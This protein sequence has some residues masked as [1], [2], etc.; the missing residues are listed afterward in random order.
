MLDFPENLPP[1]GTMV[2]HKDGGIYQV[3]AYARHSDDGAPLCIYTHRWPF[4]PGE[5]WARP[6]Q[7]WKERFT[8][9]DDLVYDAASA[10][11]R[12]AA[13]QQVT[14]AKAARKAFESSLKP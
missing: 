6:A 10:G 7:E 12:A 14:N 3:I 11:D 4:T 13:Q 2:R 1:R 8:V 5:I 9:I